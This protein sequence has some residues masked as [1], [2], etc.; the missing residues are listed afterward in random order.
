M[1]SVINRSPS[2]TWVESPLEP[3]P[4]LP[5]LSNKALEED[6][7]A[8]LYSSEV[9]SNENFD[10]K[11]EPLKRITSSDTISM[12]SNNVQ[13]NLTIKIFDADFDR[14][15][16]LQQLEIGV[17]VIK[18][19]HLGKPSNRLLH[20][21]SQYCFLYWTLPKNG[22][23]IKKLLK[24]NSSDPFYLEDLVSIRLAENLPSYSVACKPQHIDRSV[25][26]FFPTK[27]LNLT[28]HSKKQAIE[29]MNGFLELYRML[30]DDYLNA[31]NNNPTQ[32]QLKCKVS[33]NSLSTD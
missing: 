33:N 11:S 22:S 14:E 12:Y 2:T 15:Y 21:N 10:E 26:L 20:F 29:I 13:R 1:I 5:S 25:S 28:F 30:S 4:N 32:N 6:E 27:T 19:S 9:T 24:K 3:L 31:G 8:K 7:M 16:F 23:F 18:Y 17:P